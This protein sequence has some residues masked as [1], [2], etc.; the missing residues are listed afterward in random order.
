[1]TV[2]DVNW[3]LIVSFLIY[4]TSFFCWYTDDWQSIFG[5]PT[6]FG[7]GVFSIMFDILFICQHYVIFPERK[8]KKSGYKKID[9]ANDEASPLLKDE[10]RDA[11]VQTK[12]KG[13][14]KKYL[15]CFV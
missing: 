2:E 6:K 7:L 10:I 11:S 13:G 5:D 9:S 15:K 14:V 3:T 4:L 1:M 12:G 8:R